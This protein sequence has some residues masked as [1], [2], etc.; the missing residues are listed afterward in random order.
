MAGDDGGLG[1][2]DVYKIP[3][4]VSLGV[5]VGIL[6]FTMLLI[7]RLRPDLDGGIFSYARE[8]FG[9]LLGFCSAWGYWVCALVTNLAYLVILFSAFSFFTDTPGSRIFGDGNTWQ[10][11]IAA[12]CLLWAVH[13]LVL[14]GAHTATTINKIVTLAKLLPLGG[15]IILAIPAFQMDIFN[16][17]FSGTELKTPV[18]QQV[19]DTMSITLWVFIGVEGAVVVSGRAK[20]RK[21]V[22]HATLLAVLC[23][24]SV[25]VSITLLSLGVVPRAELA[26]MRNPSMAA[27]MV[28]VVGPIGEMLIAAGLIVSVCGAWLSWTIMAAEIPFLVA[29]QGSFPKIFA[30]QN[31][32]NFPA[33]SLWL[34][35]II[36]Q[37]ALIFIWL[38]GSNYNTLLPIASEMILVPYFLVGAFLFKIALKQ[39]RWPLILV[40]CGACLYGLWLIYAAG[41]IHLLFSVILYVPGLLVFLYAR[42]Q[43][44]NQKPLNISEKAFIC[45]LVLATGPAIWCT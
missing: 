22:G 18:W 20:N 36:L 4:P 26:L 42:Q 8:G 45:L 34:T 29:R 1:G 6:A 15:F 2:I 13:A 44:A 39:Q 3:V 38:T 30:T 24:L 17:D 7:T 33:A 25:Y 28:K 41:L 10:A 40:A 35:N 16:F 5:V 19:K 32:H 23:A 11:L 31:R 43:H 14:R 27:V 37:I 12:S 21:D 9:E